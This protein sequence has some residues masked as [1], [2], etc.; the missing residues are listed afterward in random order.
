MVKGLARHPIGVILLARLAV[1]KREHGQGLGKA[2]LK[3]AIANKEKYFAISPPEIREDVKRQV[4][5]YEKYVAWADAHNWTP[6][7]P[8]MSNDTMQSETRIF[9][10]QVDHCGLS[11]RL[12][13]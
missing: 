13:P 6:G 9:Q 11:P 5:N 7:A 12:L 1:D 2:L 8:P 3:D 4:A 10:Y